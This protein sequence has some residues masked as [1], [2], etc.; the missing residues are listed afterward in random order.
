VEGLQE[1]HAVAALLVYA[2]PLTR[3]LPHTTLVD[4]TPADDRS[5]DSDDEPAQP[6]RFSLPDVNRKL[7]ALG[8]RES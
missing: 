6:R 1:D 2:T 7:A 4:A 8:P 5:D 3:G